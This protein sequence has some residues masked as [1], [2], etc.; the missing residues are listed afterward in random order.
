MNNLVT[1]FTAMIAFFFGALISTLL[2]GADKCSSNHK[3]GVSKLLEPHPDIFL[4]VVI[5]SAPQNEERRQM[6]RDTWLKLGQPLPHSYYPEEFVYVPN[7]DKTGHLVV[8]SVAEQANR[9][10]IYVDWLDSLDRQPEEE[11][12]L[13]IPRKIKVKHFFSIGV[14]SLNMDL[15]IHLE[16]E[17]KKYQDLLLLPRLT[18]SYG[19]LTEKLLHSVE[20]LTHH[21]NFSYV[22]K[23]DDDSYVKMDHL[24]NELVSYDRKLIRKTPEYRMEPLPQLYWGYFN[25]KANIKTKGQWS[26]FNYYLSQKYIT[27]A[28]GGGYVISRQICEFI[29]LNARYLTPYVSEDISL[30]TWLAPLRYVYRR[31]DPRFDTGYMPRRCRSHHLVLH[32]RTTDLMQDLY[33]NRLCS[34][35]VPNESKLKRPL[36]YY[37]DWRRPSD[38]CCDS[39]VV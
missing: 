28:L 26:E 22:L 36:E 8:E 14:E 20:A 34:F 6:I 39:I 1:L 15:R 16:K 18:D 4:L 21:Y 35:E 32:K 37:Y 30:G 7:Y 10:R 5:F 3:S 27:Y 31:H 23:T 24:L 29:A 9:M 13:K 33:E 12:R 19:N 38:K 2:N 25:G 17:E 11:N